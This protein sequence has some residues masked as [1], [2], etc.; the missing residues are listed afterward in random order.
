[1]QKKINNNVTETGMTPHTYRKKCENNVDEPNVAKT[2]INQWK[3]K[4]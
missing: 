3:H 4:N 1:M 2:G